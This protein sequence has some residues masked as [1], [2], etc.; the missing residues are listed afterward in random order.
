M[1]APS[2]GSVMRDIGGNLDRLARTEL[3]LVV[4]GLRLRIEEYGEVSIYLGAAAL[5]AAVAGFF[6]LL[7]AMFALATVIPLWLAALV[8]AT[9]PGVAAAALYLY[10]RAQFPKRRSSTPQDLLPAPRG[11]A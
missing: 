4:A 7:G 5:A 3:Q 10:G 11:D 6:V 2:F 8:I 1:T 9:I